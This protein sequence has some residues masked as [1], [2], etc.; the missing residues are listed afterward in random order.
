MIKHLMNAGLSSNDVAKILNTLRIMVVWSI[1]ENHLV[2]IL[3]EP[4][5]ENFIVEDFK[6]T[7]DF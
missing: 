5:D 6:G 2:N 3:K 4:E 1:K 7:H